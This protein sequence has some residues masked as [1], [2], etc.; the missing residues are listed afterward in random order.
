MA[1]FYLSTGNKAI[2]SASSTNTASGNGTTYTNTIT[3]KASCYLTDGWVEST[4][5]KARLYFSIDGGDYT[6]YSTKKILGCGDKYTASANKTVTFE[7]SFS[8][9]TV[10]KSVKWRVWFAEYNGNTLVK[11]MVYI[12]G[13]NTVPAKPSYTITYN[14]NGGTNPPASQTKWYGTALSLR[15]GL[16][17]RTGYSLKATQWNT[18]ADGSGTGYKAGAT[19]AATTN[20]GAT[21]YAQWTANTYT[22]TFNANGGTCSTA[23]LS[24]TYNGTITLPTPT[25]TNYKFLG[26]AASSTATSG[27]AAGSSYTVTGNKT[28]YA[29]WEET[30]WKPV[31]S[32]FKA[33]RC[34]ST[35][36]LD[37]FGTY[38]Y[39][40]FD[41]ECCT[42]TNTSNVLKSVS[43][44]WS[45]GSATPSISGATSSGNLGV[46]IGGSFDTETAYT[47]SYT[48]TD[49]LGGSVSGTKAIP[50]AQ[51]PFD[52][53]GG[54]DASG[55]DASGVSVGKVAELPDYFDVG[56]T[57]RFRMA[58]EF[59]NAKGIM[60]L[61]T[62]GV[63]RHNLQPNNANDHV[64]IGYGNYSAN[65]GG[66]D[67]YGVEIALASKG[68]IRLE[69]DV[70]INSRAYG[71][72]KILWAAASYLNSNQTADLNEAISAQPHGIVLVFS[73]YNISA[74]TANNHNWHEF[75]IPKDLANNDASGG[76]NV[77]LTMGGKIYQKFL[78]IHDTQI[79]GY[80]TN[81][82]TSFSMMGQTVDNRNFVLRK[83]IGV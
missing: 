69:G 15:S 45:G 14:A 5:V 28:L 61:D 60:G 36:K 74:G 47:L 59:N 20:A 80:S 27:L 21:L 34:D 75:F 62:T 46:K 37:D 40:T 55:N 29:L 41:F 2:P 78:F 16:P 8:R 31:V 3:V 56:Y 38:L 83:V 30:Y 72:N 76:Y 32:A 42:L 77:L 82:S 65:I 19:Y 17:T 66:T 51:W 13:T 50:V 6:L 9:T 71:K 64:A 49:T 63:P 11:E 39:V 73:S 53:Y 70:K 58:A 43:F 48:V 68:D 1:G 57:S 26:W 67:I 24:K 79:A 4:G 22:I 7:H 44:S 33:E 18:K 25:H 54:K 23:S 52:I 81:N 12:G 10:A 35:G